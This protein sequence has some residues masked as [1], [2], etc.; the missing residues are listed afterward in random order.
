MPAPEPSPSSARRRPAWLPRFVLLALAAG[1]ALVG[2]VLRTKRLA[3]EAR[4]ARLTKA[5]QAWADL[6]QCAVGAPLGEGG[7]VAERV[8]RVELRAA[9]EDADWPARCTPFVVTLYEALQ[10]PEDEPPLAPGLDEE[11]RTRFGCDK[12]CTVG[13]LAAQLTDL[14]P[15]AER[16]LPREPK[17]QAPQMVDPPALRADDFPSLG[18]SVEDRDQLD[19]AS[20]RLLVRAEAGR[21]SLCR[22][23]VGPAFDCAPVTVAALP[24]SLRLVHGSEPVA[25]ASEGAE[26]ATTPEGEPL[27]LW[28]DR[29]EGHVLH[30][31]DDGWAVSWVVDGEAQKSEEVELPKGSSAPF[32]AGRQILWRAAGHDGQARLFARPLLEGDALLGPPRD[33]GAADAGHRVCLAGKTTAVLVG[34]DPTTFRILL[35]DGEAWHA[36]G[37]PALQAPPPAPTRKAPSQ[38]G[39]GSFGIIE[40]LEGDKPKGDPWSA[41]PTAPSRYFGG[42]AKP[43]ARAKKDGVGARPPLPSPA[44]RGPQLPKLT[45]VCREGEAVATWRRPSPT[46]DLIEELACRGDDCQRGQAKLRLDARAVWLNARLGEGTVV[47]WRG[48]RGALRLRHAPIAELAAAS[49]VVVMDAPDHGG[50]DTERLEAF[51]SQEAA[52]FLF[53]GK[54]LHGL[55]LDRAA[56]PS[57][58]RW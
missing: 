45:F 39:A 54:H 53:G 34:R 41:A 20:L 47:V 4:K 16:L 37:V 51:V 15:K 13:E 56:K 1:L 46:E 52:L 57:A 23:A 50:P 42:A 6:Q 44:P 11:L 27:S 30:R 17:A 21:L 55:L 26:T 7:G 8:R 5:S 25:I 18:A 3:A 12:L 40:L 31:R 33:L 22:G 48:R 24:E 58:L 36:P 29:A 2:F 38:A 35:H 28:R 10:G 43:P 19:D 14:A 9:S 49:D 32:R